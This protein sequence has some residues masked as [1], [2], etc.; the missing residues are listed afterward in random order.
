MKFVNKNSVDS[1]FFFLSVSVKEILG[2]KN[3]NGPFGKRAA[4]SQEIASLVRLVI[5][6]VPFINI[7]LLD[8]DYKF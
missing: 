6:F 3:A 4:P 7:L 5:S 8:M 2:Q 1:Q